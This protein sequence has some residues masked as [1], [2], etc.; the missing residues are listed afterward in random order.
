MCPVMPRKGLRRGG[1]R[2]RLV[3][4]QHVDTSLRRLLPF[5]HGHT[6]GAAGAPPFPSLLVSKCARS[7]DRQVPLVVTQHPARHPKMV[8]QNTRH[9]TFN[10]TRAHSILI[11]FLCCWQAGGARGVTRTQTSSPSCRPTP[12]RVPVP[13]QLHLT[14]VSAC[15]APSCHPPTFPLCPPTSKPPYSS[16]WH[17]IGGRCSACELCHV[18]G[19][20]SRTA[21]GSETPRGGGSYGHARGR[22]AA[23][24]VPCLHAYMP[25]PSAACRRR[26]P[27][28][29]R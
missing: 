4:H 23:V 24:W 20:S 25:T 16:L 8:K 2:Q 19:G 7:G 6:R 3:T 15:H 1:H 11:L 13:P 9:D 10:I 17:R 21:R 28:Q 22:V 14:D 27:S 12:Q 29:D 18:T 5:V 26:C